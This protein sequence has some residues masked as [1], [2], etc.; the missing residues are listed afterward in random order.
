MS[1]IEWFA[2]WYDLRDEE[3]VSAEEN[4]W[5]PNNE[6]QGGQWWGKW[7]VVRYVQEDDSKTDDIWWRRWR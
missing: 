1:E 5:L 7:E 4:K 3:S 2:K 6:C